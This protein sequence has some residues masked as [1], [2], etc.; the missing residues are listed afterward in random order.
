[1][2]KRDLKLYMK[3]FFIMLKINTLT[4]GGGLVIV[5]MLRKEFAEKRDWLDEQEMADFIAIAQSSPGAIVINVSVL[6]G[7]RLGGVIGTI[8]S[9]IATIL[10]PL[11]TL[12]IVTVFYTKVIENEIVQNL[13]KG[14]QAGVA[15]IMAD[16][17]ITMIKPIIKIPD[18]PRRIS[19]LSI[20]VIAFVFIVVVKINIIFIIIGSGAAGVL[21]LRRKKHDIV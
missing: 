17:V 5:S 9:V 20:V 7:Y 10:P 12:S 18:K 13:L 15:A 21:F 2:V 11:V 14:M 8:I 4:F 3:L 6:I 1:M 16:I 19:S